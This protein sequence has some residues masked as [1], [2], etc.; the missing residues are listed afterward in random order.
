[1]ER[2]HRTDCY[3]IADGEDARQIRCS[4]EQLFCGM[5]T[6]LCGEGALLVIPLEVKRYPVLLQLLQCPLD[7]PRRA[8]MRPLSFGISWVASQDANTAVSL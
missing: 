7:A 6:A 2:T 8:I 4:Q 5:V 1:M 3:R